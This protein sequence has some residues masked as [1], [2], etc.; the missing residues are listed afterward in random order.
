MELTVI[1]ILALY[2]VCV[3]CRCQ[4]PCRRTGRRGVLT[5]GCSRPAEAVFRPVRCRAIGRPCE[6]GDYRI[7]KRRRRHRPVCARDADRQRRHARILPRLALHHRAAACA[8]WLGPFL[9]GVARRRRR[10]HRAGRSVAMQGRWLEED[11]RQAVGFDWSKLRSVKPGE[12][13]LRF[14]FGAIVA[15][16]AGIV[17]AIAG[18]KF[19]GLFLAFPAILPA[20]LTLIEKKEGMTKAWA[21][22]SG[23]GVGGGGVGGVARPPVLLFRRDPLVAFVFAVV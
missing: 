8:G 19:G 3:A 18:P 6:S 16:I 17:G 5:G 4:G 9:A 12:L 15:L 23:G 22:A 10:T 7:C 2:H 11:D 20:S 14:A 1:L 13:G 21:D